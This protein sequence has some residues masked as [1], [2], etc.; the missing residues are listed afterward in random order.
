M[1]IADFSERLAAL[2]RE[3]A[4]A[5]LDGF[6]TPRADEYQSE[7]LPPSAERIAFLTGFTGSAATVVI[8]KDKAA[9]FTDGRYT[10]QAAKQL[11]RD[12]YKQFDTT[13][14]APLRW[15]E[16]SVPHGARIGYDP[17]L[18]PTDYVERL[19]KTLAS[20]GAHA[21]P[22]V[23]NFIDIVWED[24][25]KPPSS[26]FFVLEEEFSGKDSAEKRKETSAA[27]KEKKLS[28]AILTDPSS[29]AWLLN[30]RGADSANT[31]LPL[32]RAILHDDSTVQ[33]FVDPHK[34]APDL[35]LRLG[36]QVFVCA[37]ESFLAALSR[38][39][40]A[41]KTILVD[42]S[43]APS[44]I[45]ETLEQE[46]G[47]IERSEDPCA[48]PRAIKNPKELEGMRAANL[49]DSAAITDFL[50]WLDER[51]ENENITELAAEQ[52]LRQLREA[53]L[54]YRGGSFETISAAGEHGAIVHYRATEESDIRLQQGQL[55]LVDSG[56]QYLDGTTDVTRTIALGE[57]TP[58]MRE[59][60]T[61]VLKG[62]IALASIH[63]PEG[64]TGAE[65]D[66]LARQ[67]LWAVGG[68]Y[69]HGTGHGVGSY[70][71]VHEGPQ[72]ISRRNRTVLRPNMVLS[73]EPGFYKEGQYGIRIESLMA[74]VE[75]AEFPRK[76]LGFETITFVP[77]DRRL[78]DVA[79][80]TLAEIDWINR[81]HERVR[82]KLLPLVEHGLWLKA[83]TQKI[84]N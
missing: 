41:G 24:R 84:E 25:P 42:P 81:Y 51:W 50:A 59:Y 60:F 63:F 62:H 64:T 39:A 48:L 40:R 44:V 35:V 65:L 13:A 10:I 32:S 12:L 1:T 70:L 46:K 56:G 18:L 73:N 36:E 38:L 16:E 31:P 20:L 14:K 6:I 75:L 45:I 15:I 66:V 54:H 67:F 69:Q 21:V 4:S 27:L 37:P 23:R 47:R 26:P 53:K 28:A 33:W 3:I 79:L 43:Q 76:M 78:I 5:G 57:P 72:G 34:V 71:G 83:A 19:K 49:R 9:F 29:V 80:L 7:S 17:W 55:Y 8:L 11:P 58:E 22:I 30:I 52:K 2:R 74:V 68:D 77:I 82:E 61:R